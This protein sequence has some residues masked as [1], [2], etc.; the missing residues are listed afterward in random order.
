MSPYESSTFIQPPLV[1][2]PFSFPKLVLENTFIAEYLLP[3]ILFIVLDVI[4]AFLL[5]GIGHYAFHLSLLDNMGATARQWQK[6]LATFLPIFYLLNPVMIASCVSMSTVI[7]NNLGLAIMLYFAM[8]NN[9]IMSTFG[10]AL[11]IYLTV[12]PI[13]LVIPL[14]ILLHQVVASQKVQ[15]GVIVR[16]LVWTVAWQALLQYMS[17]SL[18]SHSWEFVQQAYLYPLAVRFIHKF[19]HI[20]GN[21]FDTKLGKLLVLFYRSFRSF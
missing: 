12:Y 19:S 7:F 17:Y 9:I 5:H 11:S 1:L 2:V 8:K 13:V 16:V 20:V 18:M 14:V 21:R 6:N 10:L 3:R 4:I 15:I